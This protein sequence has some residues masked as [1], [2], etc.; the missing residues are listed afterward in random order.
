MQSDLFAGGFVMTNYQFDLST[1]NEKSNAELNLAITD[2]KKNRRAP[3]QTINIMFHLVSTFGALCAIFAGFDGFVSVL[4]LLFPQ[5][6][7]TCIIIFGIIAAI[8]SF[9]AFIARDRQ[10]IAEALGIHD[11]GTTNLSDSYVFAVEKYL[12]DEFIASLGKKNLV[13]DMLPNIEYLKSIK[14]YL[15][16]KS[17]NNQ[18]VITQPMNILIT[19]S[20]IGIGAI[21]LFS[22]GFFIGQGLGTFLSLLFVIHNPLLIITLSV[23][24]GVFALTVY[25]Y[26]EKPYLEKYINN[27]L[28]TQENKVQESLVRLEHNIA[29]LDNLLALQSSNSGQ[30][31]TL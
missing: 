11:Y 17:K 31:L 16:D 29:V 1:I 21:L 2:L 10:A 23:L 13:N 9:L 6:S 15:E 18:Q 30:T 24:L 14:T 19:Q 26:V 22:D 7:L 25:F 8:C 3:T 5:L 4:T 20:V 27:T 28:F 12:H